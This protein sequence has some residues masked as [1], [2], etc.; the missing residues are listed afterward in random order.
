MSN[1]DPANPEASSSSASDKIGLL[2]IVDAEA[3][4]AA[5][6]LRVVEDYVRFVLDD[7]HLT[8][9]AKQLRHDLTAALHSFSMA[10]R[11]AARES[12]ADVGVELSTQVETQRGS[13][14]DVAAASFQ[15]LTQALRS[16]EEYGKLL[17]PPAA[18]KIEKIRFRAYTLQ[19]VVS[20]TAD[21]QARLAAAR[22]Y[23]L[24]DGGADEETFA[25]L[26]QS[27]V[28]AGVHVL[29]LRD[30]QLGDRELLSRA[31]RFGAKFA[32]ALP[33]CSS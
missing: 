4:C 28:E 27:L 23:V 8:G 6:G 5:E 15:R 17:D 7:S 29:Q 9:V 31:R 18:G 11:L 30:K 25:R 2:R 14:A 20:I 26:A 12:Q 33:H 10:E 3:N 16:L 19:R 24:L 13:L 22:L 21:S 1:R 32:A